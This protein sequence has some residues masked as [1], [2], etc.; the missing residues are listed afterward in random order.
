MAGYQEKL[1][2]LKAMDVSVLAASVDPLDKAE[3]VAADLSYPMAYGLTKADADTVGAWWEDRRGIFQATE[4]VVNAEGKVLI[5]TYCSGPVGRMPAID[6]ERFIAFQ[7][8]Q[9]LGG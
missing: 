6:M 2:D 8:K 1:E 9:R 3:E 7:E 4:F 5:S